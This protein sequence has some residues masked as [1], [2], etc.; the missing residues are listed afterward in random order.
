M[1][2]VR[3]VRS[4]YYTLHYYLADDTAEILEN[5]SRPGTTWAAAETASCTMKSA[6]KDLKATLVSGTLAVIRIQPSIAALPCAR[7]RPG[8]CSALQCLAAPY[9]CCS[10]CSP[11][12][13]PQ[14]SAS[15]A[16][17]S[18]Y[19]KA[20]PPEHQRHSGNGGRVSLAPGAS[21]ERCSKAC[22]GV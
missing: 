15:C 12:V 18:N 5:M 7:L 1:V 13:S 19:P 9:P 8:P 2:I 21:R 17:S 3:C 22:H 4:R 6:L 11:P 16:R 14:F 10:P 20:L